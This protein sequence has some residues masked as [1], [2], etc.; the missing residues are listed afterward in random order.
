MAGGTNASAPFSVS[1]TG[2]VVANKISI[3]KDGIKYFDSDTGFTQAAFSQ[4][5]QN[6][7]STVT[8]FAYEQADNSTAGTKIA[9]SSGSAITLSFIIKVD[10]RSFTGSDSSSPDTAYDKIP[11]SLDISVEHAASA[12]TNAS[13][14]TTVGSAM[15]FTKDSTQT[16]VDGTSLSPAS[17][18]LSSTDY[19]IQVLDLTQLN[20][21]YVASTDL[22]SSG[23]AVDSSGDLTVTYSTTYSLAA[24]TT[25]Y[26][27]AKVAKTG[28]DS[29]T[30]NNAT[31]FDR[32]L[33]ITDD[34]GTGFTVD[35]SGGSSADAAGDITGVT[36]GTGL[37]GGGTSGT[38][39]LN[40][41]GL[42]VSEL[43]G[44]SLTTSSES[45]RFIVLDT[46][47]ICKLMIE[48]KVLVIQLIQEIL[49]QS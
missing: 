32:V 3:K 37:S 46:N 9:N 48:L 22:F 38:V 15:T 1:K 6:L 8:T 21:G 12:S 44:A 5:A 7:G 11:T 20:G 29:A 25:K 42:T 26:F 4:I 19:G 27:R 30:A 17:G 10:V 18:T 43:A 13:D 47:D 41:S 28:G 33:E 35:G 14:Y 24:G 45:F 23:D 49:Q 40:V 36:A 2:D 34:G 16:S 39:T 31:L